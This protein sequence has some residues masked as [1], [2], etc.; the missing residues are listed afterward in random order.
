MQAQGKE[1]DIMQQIIEKVMTDKETDCDDGDS[2]VL[3]RRMPPWCSS[4]LT[5]LMRTLDSRKTAKSEAV[6]KKE[7]RIRP[8]SERSPPNGLPKWVLQTSTR[9]HENSS[10]WTDSSSTPPSTQIHSPMSSPEPSPQC[11]AVFTLPSQSSTQTQAR[12]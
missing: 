8:F 11:S 1:V 4:K 9:T 7:R 12:T 5:K 3:V 10:S 2:Q 6:P